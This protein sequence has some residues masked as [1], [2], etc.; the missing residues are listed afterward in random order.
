M[1]AYSQARLAAACVISPA[2]DQPSLIE[3][4]HGDDKTEVP[5]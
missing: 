1:A 3:P 5:C 2:K 4:L